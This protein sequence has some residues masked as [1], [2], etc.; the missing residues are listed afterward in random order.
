MATC[1]GA[2][3]IRGQEVL[4]GCRAAHKSYPGCWDIL[5]GHVE[6]G[7]SVEAALTRELAEEVG[8]KP[9]EWRLLS[10]CRFQERDGWSDLLIYRI[11]SWAG[12]PFLAND[13][14]VELRWLPLADAC[15]LERL[16]AE[17]Y[18]PILRRLRDAS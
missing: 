11:D 8:I 2:L 18:R 17:E 15:D 7:E 12:D 10:S 1:V 3:M 13:E 16:A 4:L 9:L 6:P 14:H 5:G